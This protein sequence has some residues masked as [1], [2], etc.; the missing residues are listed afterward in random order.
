VPETRGLLDSAARRGAIFAAAVVLA[1]LAGYSIGKAS[2][3]ASGEPVAGAPASGDHTHGPQESAAAGL[4]ATVGDYT[5]VP[6]ATVFPVGTAQ[7]MRFAVKGPS[8]PVLRY[9]TVHDRQLHL[10]VARADLGGYQH[11]HPELDADGYWTVPLTLAT[12]GTY[13]LYA[14]FTLSEAT[15]RQ[16]ALVLGVQL[17]AAGAY[18]PQPLPGPAAAATVDDLA[19]TLTGA[20]RTGGSAPMIA[21]VTRGGAPVPLERY[22]GAL[23]HL[24]V[25][26]ESDLGYLHVHPDEQPVDNGVRFWVSAPG[27]GRYRAFFDFSTGGVV[28]TAAFTVQVG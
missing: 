17:T 19:V 12:P 2:I 24:V 6:D 20:P 14:D 23:G 10:I 9:E 22:L 25:L 28:R 1:L 11:L 21:R 8:G 15:G 27:P 18:A 5:L 16:L 4:S 3:P 7:P 26:R 13:R